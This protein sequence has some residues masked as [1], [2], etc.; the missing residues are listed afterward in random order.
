MALFTYRAITTK[1]FSPT[2]LQE[3]DLA[4][5]QVTKVAAQDA[6]RREDV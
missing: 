3:R 1:P 4:A 5:K 6:Y 2:T